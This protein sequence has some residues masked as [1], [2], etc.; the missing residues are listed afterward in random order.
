MQNTFESDS[1]E[2][3]VIAFASMFSRYSEAISTAGAQVF[4]EVKQ[5]IN[6]N[7]TGT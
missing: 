3:I 2:T 6:T 1:E 4:P 5:A 7:R